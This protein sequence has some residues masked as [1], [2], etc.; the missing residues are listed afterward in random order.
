MELIQKRLSDKRVF[1]LEEDGIKFHIKTPS[2]EVESKFRYEELGLEIFTIKKKEGSWIFI[3][4]TMI[5]AYG[6]MYLLDKYEYQSSN[7]LELVALFIGAIIFF[8][9]LIYMIFETRKSLIGINGGTKSFSLLRDRPSKEKV[10]E[11]IE[12]LHDRIRNK[13]VEL[14]VRPDDEIID[15][16]TKLYQLRELLDR[17]IITKSSFDE[18]SESLKEDNNPIGFMK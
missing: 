8:S 14:I 4:M 7:N 16:D 17:G 3:V 5:S 15:L 1:K 9:C 18:I 10:D 6:L 11:F 2:Q 13:Y 12:E